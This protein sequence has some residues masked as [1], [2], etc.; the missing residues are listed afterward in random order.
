MSMKVRNPDTPGRI[1][2]SAFTS[3]KKMMAKK[4]VSVHLKIKL[5]SKLSKF[6]GSPNST[7][8]LSTPVFLRQGIATHLCL[9]VFS[10]VLSNLS[11][12]HKDHDGILS[13]K[14]VA[15]QKSL[16]TT[17][18]HLRHQPYSKKM[19]SKFFLSGRKVKLK[20]SF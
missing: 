3:L 1:L 19:W 16:R 15:N 13:Q 18:L 12:K 14:C 4:N 11:Y 2:D 17:V 8:W 9:Q 7:T 6:N 20:N 10:S 5:N